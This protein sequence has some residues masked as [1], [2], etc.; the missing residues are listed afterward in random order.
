MTGKCMDLP[1]IYNNT[2]SWKHGRIG[3]ISEETLPTITVATPPEFTNGVPNLWSPEHLFVASAN[4]CLMTTFLAIAE[5]SKL[6]FTAYKAEA[7]GKLDKVDGKFAI[8]EITITPEITLA[9]GIDESRAL[10]ILEKS[11]A[12]CLISNSMKTKIVLKPVFHRT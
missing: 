3:E 1:F 9:E 7:V 5:N 4:V 6:D 11:E 2:V 10:R 8:I 12:N